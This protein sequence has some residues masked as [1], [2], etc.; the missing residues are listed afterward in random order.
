MAKVRQE[1]L[2]AIMAK[3][4]ADRTEAEKELL[5]I[6][7]DTSGSDIDW[8]AAFQ[9]PRFKTLVKE[10]NDAQEALRTAERKKLEEENNFKSLYESTKA[11]LDVEKSKSSKVESLE[12]TLQKTLDAELATLTADAKKLVPAKLSVEDKLEWITANRNV[13]AKATVKD[14]SVGGRKTLQSGKPPSKGVVLSD[15]EKR[16]AQIFGYTEDEYAKFRDTGS[17][18]TSPSFYNSQERGR[19]V[20][21]ESDEEDTVEE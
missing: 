7:E 12:S 16:M 11:E 6:A 3:A 14:V 15:D 17:T 4:E 13:L 18:S 21:E 2:D 8:Q 1:T 19:A 20:A 5:A 10:R 9:H